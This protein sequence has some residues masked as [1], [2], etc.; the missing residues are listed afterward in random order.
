MKRDERIPGEI[1]LL[2]NQILMMDSITKQQSI[3]WPKNCI[4]GDI[5]RTNINY[6]S[7]TETE[8]V[9]LI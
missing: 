7:I 2:L 1:V 9:E 4:H 5:L 6:G 8:G 3:E